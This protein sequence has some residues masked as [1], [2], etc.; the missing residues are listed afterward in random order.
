MTGARATLLAG[1]AAG[2]LASGPGLAQEQ[3]RLR[4]G[5][6]AAFSRIALDVPGL[7]EWTAETRGRTVELRFP[8]RE[9][10]FD[11]RQ[12]FPE[13]RISRVSG[14]RVERRE[15]GTTLILSLSCDCIAEAYEFQ[16]GMLVVDVRAKD[17]EPAPRET[18][19][20]TESPAPVAEAREAAAEG[21]P[22]ET[23]RPAET[24]EKAGVQAE[25]GAQPSAGAEPRP[26]APRNE[27]PAPDAAPQKTSQPA[28]DPITI[29]EAQRRL[30]EQLTRAADQG[31]VDFRAS[32]EAAT[33]ETETSAAPHAGP[34]EALPDAGPVEVREPEPPAASEPILLRTVQLDARTAFDRDA[35]A[36]ASRSAPPPACADDAMLDPRL[37]NPAEDAVSEMAALRGRLVGEFDRPDGATA[38][39]LAR[40][41]TGLGFGAEARETLRAFAP[42]GAERDLLLDLAAL[43]DGGAPAA[44]GPLV[45][46]DACAGRIGTWRLA[47]GLP[48]AEDADGA[49]MEAA[50]DGFA[51]LPVPLRR[52]VGPGLVEALL[53]AD[54]LEEAERARLLLDR[55]P[56]DHG[57]AWRLAVGRLALA[58]GERDRAETLLAAAA[59][60]DGPEATDALLALAE[61]RLERDEPLEEG[62]VADVAA[63]AFAL[64]GSPEGERLLVAEILGRAGRRELGAAL[65]AVEMEMR[66]D[67]SRRAELDGALRRILERAKAQEVGEMD[68]A[69]SILA[70]R[71]LI[72]EDA[73]FDPARIRVGGELTSIGLANAAAEMLA[74]ALSR[75]SEPARLAMAEAEI[76]AGDPVS[77]L[78][79]LEGLEGREAAELRARALAAQDLRREAYSAVESAL[80]PDAPERA[81]M[82]WLGSAWADAAALPQD[83]PR[84]ALAGRMTQQGLSYEDTAAP[85][86]SPSL[87]GARALL[88]AAASVRREVQEALD[89]G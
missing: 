67:P 53:K 30:L 19:N 8:D 85:D 81:E 61:S 33:P 70:H 15:T 89:G 34:D 18:P 88:D 82:A 48:P 26:D 29:A 39:A 56:G 32:E 50:L 6:H 2:L 44:D 31:L 79:R 49:L 59:A 66:S 38:L 5:E 78:A 7:G 58:Q 13:R 77:A 21:T 47:A 43:L 45:R 4:A 46:S 16:P 86:G 23:P 71:K 84:R 40:L 22:P 10:A 17:D 68:Y 1:L 76:A 12:I 63:A 27:A 25:A 55:A 36:A 72:G 14:A 20:A 65:E 35:P 69:A 62:L 80:P 9:F 3:A 52:R 87:A 42:E 75:G 54:A 37:W 24:A 28:P 60:G 73:A 74:P 41:Q 83:D 51:E 57:D 64:R 11:T